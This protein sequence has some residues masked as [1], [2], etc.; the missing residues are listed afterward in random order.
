MKRIIEWYKRLPKWVR[1]VLQYGTAP[2]WW[3]VTLVVMLVVW[4]VFAPVLGLVE[5][6]EDF[7]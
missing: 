7:R 6:W 1:F 4:C 3:P 5:L 2:I